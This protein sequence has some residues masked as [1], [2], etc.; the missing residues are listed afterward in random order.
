M[1]TAV[2]PSCSSAAVGGESE[3]A[4]VFHCAFT[5]PAAPGREHPFI[6]RAPALPHTV[7]HLHLCPQSR[8]T[9]CVLP[10]PGAGAGP[11]QHR[12][13]DI[14]SDFLFLKYENNISLCLS[15]ERSGWVCSPASGRASNV[16]CRVWK[17]WLRQPRR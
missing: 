14:L 13:L 12:F 16:L 4:H 1:A 15:R 10:P 5:L 9:C 11:S 7:Q 17:G 6:P 3:R 2:R 8:E